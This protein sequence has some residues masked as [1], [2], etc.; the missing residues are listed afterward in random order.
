MR[1]ASKLAGMTAV[2]LGC[3]ATAAMAAPAE[4]AGAA[5]LRSGPGSGYRVVAS[6]PPHA[7]VDIGNCAGNWC[8][9]RWRGVGGYI[10]LASLA[11]APPPVVDPYADEWDTDNARDNWVRVRRNGEWVWVPHDDRKAHDE[12][13]GNRNRK[14]DNDRRQN[15][16]ALRGNGGATIWRPTSGMQ[17]NRQNND[18][19]AMSGGGRNGG[20]DG[21]GRDGGGGGRGGDGGGGGNGGGGNG[22]GGGRGR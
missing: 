18:R 15:A 16:A 20:R 13:K 1:L 4:T 8:P 2:L 5:A 11:I 21:G 22:G 7:I 19:S 6:L 10:S 12:R 17:D 3:M 9:A 14:A